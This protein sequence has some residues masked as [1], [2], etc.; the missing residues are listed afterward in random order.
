[1]AQ[2]ARIPHSPI[3]YEHIIE[4]SHDKKY[5]VVNDINPIIKPP[6]GTTEMNS[7]LFVFLSCLFLVM[8]GFNYVL[9][10]GAMGISEMFDESISCAMVDVWGVWFL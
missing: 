1:M 9:V 3:L 2:T 8:V 7:S 4:T 10:Y 5:S 6:P